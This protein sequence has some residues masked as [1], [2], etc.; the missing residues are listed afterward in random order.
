MVAVAF[1]PQCN[2]RHSVNRNARLARKTLLVNAQ[3]V[4]R[5]TNRHYDHNSIFRDEILRLEHGIACNT[6]LE[7]IQSSFASDADNYRRSESLRHMK[8]GLCYRAVEI[9]T[10]SL[11]SM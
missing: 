3:V 6:V 10:P 11:I 9:L 7:F 8:P 4:H 2:F 1:V 5:G